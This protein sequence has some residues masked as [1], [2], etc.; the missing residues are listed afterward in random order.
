[1][2]LDGTRS[3]RRW[4]LLCL[5]LT[6]FKTIRLKV[7]KWPFTAAELRGLHAPTNIVRTQLT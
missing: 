1:M 2:A 6:D 4:L 3:W 5:L 7:A